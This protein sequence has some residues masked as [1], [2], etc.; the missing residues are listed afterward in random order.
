MRHGN[1]G[2]VVL[3]FALAAGAA[4]AGAD[5]INETN[6]AALEWGLSGSG[7]PI[8]QG[9][10]TLYPAGITVAGATGAILDVNLTLNDGSIDDSEDLNMVLVSPA[11]TVVEIW[12]G[13]GGADP[14]AGSVTFDDEAA[15][16]I[17]DSTFPGGS[18]VYQPSLHGG[19][20]GVVTNP[21]ADG[22]TLSLFDGEDA[23]GTWELYVYDAWAGGTG[24]FA[25]GWTL[26]IVTVP[27]PAAASIL[28]FGCIGMTRRRR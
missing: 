27:T 19:L 8:T 10:V 23:N 21:L 6:S 17:P 12:R 5:V 14:V 22:S 4:S 15:G 24:S 13:A 25:G 16:V 9:P 11:G 26:D 20:S 3:G 1:I 18:G 2:K 7:N 28:A